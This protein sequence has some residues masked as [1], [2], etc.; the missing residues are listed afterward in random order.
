MAILTQSLQSKWQAMLTQQGGQVPVAELLERGLLGSVSNDNSVEASPADSSLSV[1][2]A[3]FFR[4]LSLL[5][6]RRL[7]QH[8]AMPKL[9]WEGLTLRCLSHQAGGAAH[10]SGS[11]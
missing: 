5:P 9:R 2:N 3:C 1:S 7:G 8:P 4:Q 6:C 10:T 11:C